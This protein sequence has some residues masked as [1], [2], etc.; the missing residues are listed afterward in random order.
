MNMYS[1]N[2]SNLKH[3]LSKLNKMNCSYLTD[4]VRDRKPPL[5]LGNSLYTEAQTDEFP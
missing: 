3:K 4:I 5:G 1:N 2:R